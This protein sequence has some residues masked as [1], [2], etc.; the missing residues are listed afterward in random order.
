[1]TRG[2]F[3]VGR[4]CFKG[5]ERRRF[6]MPIPHRSDFDAAALCGFAR[7]SK[8]APQARRLLALAAIYEGATRTEAARIGGVTRQIVRDWVMRFNAHG[9]EGLIDRKPP[10]PPSR[11]TDAHRTALMAR[12]D[13]GPIPSVHGVVRWRLVDLIEWLWDEFRLRISKQTL[14]REVRALGY[15]KLSARPRHHAKSEVEVSAFK[16]PSP[17]VWRRSPRR[18]AASP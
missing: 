17:P 5:G 2:L 4:V 8:D 3:E 18:Q 12:I 6:A 10:G 7:R 13:D 11:L 9:L 16:K 1:M 14:S 15:R